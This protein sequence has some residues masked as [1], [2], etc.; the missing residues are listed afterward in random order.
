[1]N[2]NKITVVLPPK[3]LARPVIYPG[4]YAEC[5]ECKTT[6]WIR[7]ARG[8]VGTLPERVC[9]DGHVVPGLRGYY[10][11]PDDLLGTPGFQNGDVFF[12]E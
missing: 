8:T 10:Q 2:A 3:V 5:P 1:M 12:T 7:A 11:V 9:E 4:V 6:S